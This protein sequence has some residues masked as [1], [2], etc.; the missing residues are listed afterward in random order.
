MDVIPY[1]N[2]LNEST[3]PKKKKNVSYD[4]QILGGGLKVVNKIN[5]NN[6]FCILIWLFKKKKN[7]SLS[8]KI[9]SELKKTCF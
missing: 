8:R 6:Q 2:F 9:T 3:F 5:S 7:L 1:C 4:L